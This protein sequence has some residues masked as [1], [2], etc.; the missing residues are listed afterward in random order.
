MMT[1]WNNMEIY[2]LDRQNNRR[3]G[4]KLWECF[5]KVISQSL[6]KWTTNNHTTDC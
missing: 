5:P 3:Y 4:V 6:D 2:S 1:M